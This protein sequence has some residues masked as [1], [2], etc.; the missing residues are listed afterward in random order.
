MSISVQSSDW[1]G[2]RSTERSAFFLATQ[3]Q[4]W[5]WRHIYHTR[6]EEAAVNDARSD[7]KLNVESSFTCSASLRTAIS[8]WA[9]SS[10]GT[11]RHK[12]RGFSEL[13]SRHTAGGQWCWPGWAPFR[14]CYL[15]RRGEQSTFTTDD[16]VAYLTHSRTNVPLLRSAGPNAYH[17]TGSPPVSAPPVSPPGPPVSP[18]PPSP[19]QKSTQLS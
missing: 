10:C 14:R 11:S 3:R 17:H 2:A 18:P 7:A 16:A 4:A 12:Q 5:H 1:M 8:V 9:S 15:T 19:V 6:P 13:S